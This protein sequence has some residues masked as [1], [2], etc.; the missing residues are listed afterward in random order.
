MLTEGVAPP[1]SYTRVG[2]FIQDVDTGGSGGQ[3]KLKL[4]IVIYRKQ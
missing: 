3:K 1:L 2:S 4:T